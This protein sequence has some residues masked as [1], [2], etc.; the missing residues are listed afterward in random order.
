MTT[1]ISFTYN[2]INCDESIGQDTV[3]LNQ[4]EPD[5]WEIAKIMNWNDGYPVDLCQLDSLVKRLNDEIYLNR[6][7]QYLSDDLD[8]D[9]IEIKLPLKMPE[10]LV[11]IADK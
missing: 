7:P 5:L 3:Y 2:I 6:L 8:F 9:E 10:E 11:T 4:P 1:A